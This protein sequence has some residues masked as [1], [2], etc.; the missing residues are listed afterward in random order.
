MKMWYQAAVRN[1]GLADLVLSEVSQDKHRPMSLYMVYRG[2]VQD[3]GMQRGWVKI[4]GREQ[5]RNEME[6]RWDNWVARE[7]SKVWVLADR[8]RW[9]Q[10]TIR[11]AGD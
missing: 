5:R 2:T 10:G 7:V 1:D 4:I 11:A 3:E 9:A 6:G 8:S